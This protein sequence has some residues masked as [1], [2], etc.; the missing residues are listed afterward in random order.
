MTNRMVRLARRPRGMVTREDFTIEDGP[1]PEP[2]PGEF[3]VRI[4]CISLD[5]AMRGWMNEGRSY[6]P[7]VALG[8]VMRAG[9]AGIVE[10]S[11]NRRSRKAMR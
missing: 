1:V 6:V 8:E 11:N 7:P 9:A 2:G 4:E 3:R 5:P 10:K